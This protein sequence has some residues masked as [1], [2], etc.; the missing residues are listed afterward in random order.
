MRGWTGMRQEKVL[1][2]LAAEGLLA[3]EEVHHHALGTCYR[4]DTVVEPLISKQWFVRMKPLAEPA[5]QVVRE[6]KI[7]FV[8]ERFAKI[9]LNWVDN[10]RDWCISRQLWWEHRIDLVLP[11]LRYGDRCR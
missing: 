9:Y 5:A 3:G 1:E 10:I 8:P 7:R 6:G 4:C 11:G 2:D